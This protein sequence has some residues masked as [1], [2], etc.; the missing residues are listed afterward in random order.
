MNFTNWKSYKDVSKT[1]ASYAAKRGLEVL[2]YNETNDIGQTENVYVEI[3]LDDDQKELPL[4]VYLV[5]DN[6]LQ[7]HTKHS[8]Y[9]KNNIED[10]L[11]TVKDEKQLRQVVQ[12]IAE[13]IA[14]S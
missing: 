7:F 2:V 14:N 6:G 5:T 13:H 4:V 1:T 8:D 9:H 11:Y 10:L 12:H 3:W